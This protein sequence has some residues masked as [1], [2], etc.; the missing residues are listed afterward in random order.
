M[1]ATPFI[2]ARVGKVR[3]IAYTKLLAIPFV[4]M[5]PLLPV[6]AV[7]VVPFVIRAVLSDVGGPIFS[8]FIM[9]QVGPHER[10]A[11]AGLIHSASEFPMGVAGL[12]MVSSGEWNFAFGA[13]ALFTLLAYLLFLRLFGGLERVAEPAVAT[14]TVP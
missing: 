3:T 1:M 9:E 7:A 12:I 6:A 4:L 11:T 13:S 5:I 10:G 14:E 2:V 8:L